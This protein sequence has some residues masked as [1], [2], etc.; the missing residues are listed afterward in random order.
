[1]RT[2]SARKTAWGSFFP[3]E[4]ARPL[5]SLLLHR[6]RYTASRDTGIECLVI[7]CLSGPAAEEMLCG[8]ATDGGDRDERI[9]EAVANHY[10]LRDR[11]V[12]VVAESQIAS[13]PRGIVL[14]SFD[15]GHGMTATP[16]TP[17]RLRS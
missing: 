9:I 17:R 16:M 14:L 8:A 10:Q 2:S 6:G 11:A 7:L 15:V 3:Q 13:A 4:A 12:K 1:M 5:T